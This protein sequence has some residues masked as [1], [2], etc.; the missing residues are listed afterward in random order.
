MTTITSGLPGSLPTDRFTSPAF[1]DFDFDRHNAEQPAMWSAFNAGNPVRIPIIL[2]TN[3][4]YFMF[5]KSANP[6]GL[7]F[8]NYSG[9][10]DVMFDAQLQFQRWSKFNLLQDAELGLPEKWNLCPD[11]Q[12]Y[13]EAGWFGCRVHYF[14]D[15]VPD[16]LPE[17]A[18]APERIMEN[19]L[20]DPFGGLL[21]RGLAF[22]EHFKARAE[23]ETFLDRPIAVGPPFTGTD[24]PLTVACNL[25]GADFVCEAM[26]GEPDRLHKLLSFITDGIILRITAWRKAA[27]LPSPQPGFFFADDSVALISADMYRDHVLPHHRRI[28]DTLHGT[29]S[30]RGIHLCGDS[31]R[32]FRTLVDELNVQ[33]FDTGFP[34]DFGALRRELGTEVRIQG[35]PHVDFLLRATPDEVHAEVRR[36]L[37]TGILEGGRFMLREGNNLAPYTPLENTEAMYFAGREAG[38]FAA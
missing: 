7:D 36:I 32:H 13:Y 25:F 16:T 30:P 26:A 34:V 22:W 38:S 28:C 11:F 4:R 18:D 5:N 23:R 33:T 12:N 3:T 1:K 2:G 9:D 35:G 27:G 24:G 20:P 6:D 10:P 21:E 17:F 19:G 8:R 15:Q 29:S 37:Q 14:P 31:S